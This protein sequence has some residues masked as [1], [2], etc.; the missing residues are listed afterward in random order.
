MIVAKPV[1]A[2]QFWI[3]KQNNQKIGNI[4]VAADGSYEVKILDRVNT[5][6]TIPMVR[7]AIGI[8]F[9]PAE[10]KSKS[11]TDNVHGFPTGCRAHNGMWDIKRKLPL[12]T[13][14]SK[15]KSWFA[16]GWYQVKQH[17]NWKIVQN[18]KLIVLERY[19]YR[20]PFQTKEQANDQSVS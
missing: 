15:S 1:I 9:E 10:K 16:A 14:L 4:Q 13:K 18:P 7:K 11:A 3:L 5:Y 20:G 8:E 12:F 2:N 17:R 6:K 19:A